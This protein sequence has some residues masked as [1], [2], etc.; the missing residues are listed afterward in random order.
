MLDFYIRKSKLQINKTSNILSIALIKISSMKKRTRHL[1]LIHLI[2]VWVN[3]IQ[4]TKKT[5]TNNKNSLKKS[6]GRSMSKLKKINNR[7]SRSFKNNKMYTKSKLN[8]L[9]RI[10]KMSRLSSKSS[11]R[12]RITGIT[13]MLSKEWCWK[14]KKME[15]HWQI[16][17]MSLISISDKY[18][19]SLVTPQLN[20]SILICFQ[21]KSTLTIMLI[22]MRRCSMK[23]RRKT[24]KSSSGQR[25][26]VNR[27]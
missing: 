4:N 2:A 6:H 18:L 1:N 21:L 22:Q 5:S 13:G 16:W 20:N 24:T 15:I 27:F 12:W 8:T 9:K 25:R 10:S 7:G 26:Q 17:S 23:I 19:F 3:I 11:K 14:V